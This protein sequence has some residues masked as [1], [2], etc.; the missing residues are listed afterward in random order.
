MGTRVGTTRD[1]AGAC[2]EGARGVIGQTGRGCNLNSI[3][4]SGEVIFVAR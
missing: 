3:G 4:R 1:R 2:P